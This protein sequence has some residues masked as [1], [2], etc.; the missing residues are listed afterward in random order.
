MS[1]QGWFPLRLTGLISLLS[2][3]S[4][5]FL[6]VWFSSLTQSCP[7]LCDPV[8]CSA[9][10]FSV[11]HQLLELKLMSIQSVTPSNHLILYCPLL[12][13]P[14]IFP[15]IRGFFNESALHIKWPK[16]W[17][18]CF[19]ISPSN[20]YSELILWFDLSVVKGILKVFSST[21]IQKHQF[22]GAQP[23]LLSSSHIYTWQL[24]KPYLWP[25][26]PLL[27]KWCL[28]FLICCLSLSCINCLLLT[29]REM[30]LHMD[31]TR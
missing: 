4:I 5:P 30:T 13:M 28:C 22:F 16:Y 1:I 10:S 8:D 20:G 12:F 21:T 9:L 2:K 17:S 23:F 18:F 6:V 27:A 29:T 19:S 3:S 25:Y 26:R 7:T 31:I 14:S 15:S 11:H 24:E